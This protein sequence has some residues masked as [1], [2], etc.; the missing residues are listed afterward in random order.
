M[1]NAL[2]IYGKIQRKIP[3]DNKIW[4]DRI[5]FLGILYPYPHSI[6]MERWHRHQS[7]KCKTETDKK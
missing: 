1:D 5:F 2:C 7:K 4:T 3:K 6:K